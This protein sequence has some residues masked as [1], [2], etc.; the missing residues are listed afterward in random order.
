M[1]KYS[2]NTPSS[3]VVDILSH[4]KGVLISR[5]TLQNTVWAS[6]KVSV[7][8]PLGR[9]DVITYVSSDT[10]YGALYRLRND[11]F[12]HSTVVYRQK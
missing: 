6:L 9:L 7:F 5:K 4:E 8:Q 3:S 11:Q 1:S 10:N 12:H 2:F